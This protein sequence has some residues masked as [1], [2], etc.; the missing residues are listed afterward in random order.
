MDSFLLF[1]DEDFEIVGKA[2][3][4]GGEFAVEV[5]VVTADDFG[6]G[7]LTEELFDFLHSFGGAAVKGESFDVRCCARFS[8]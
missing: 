8:L 1:V 4:E 6:A 2:E 3:N 7:H 5:V